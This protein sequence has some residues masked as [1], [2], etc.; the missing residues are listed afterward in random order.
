MCLRYIA[1]LYFLETALWIE[2]CIIFLNKSRSVCIKMKLSV[3]IAAYNEE[4]NIEPLT[5]RIIRILDLNKIPFEIIYVVE[6]NDR[7]I[8]ILRRYQQKDPRLKLIYHS[9]PLG[10]GNAFKKGLMNISKESTHVLTMDADLNH[11]P[12]EIPSFFEAMGRKNAD[13]IVG[14]R[15][16]QGGSINQF[17]FYKRVISKFTN[18][19]VDLLTGIRVKDKTSNYRLYTRKAADCVAKKIF[20][21]G[22]ECVVEMLLIVARNNFKITEVPIQFKWRVHGTSKL[23]IFKTGKGYMWLFIHYFLKF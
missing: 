9:V 16:I 11:Q 8:D 17:P 21:P 20:F 4:Y 6:G 3:V 22:F 19:M 1:I 14:S 18:T 5:S 23:K 10:L 12:E 15:Y 13:V 7:T 2:K